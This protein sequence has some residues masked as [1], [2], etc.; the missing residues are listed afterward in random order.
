M[1]I[2]SCL[3]IFILGSIGC[4]LGSSL[5]ALI[6]ARAVQGLGGGGLIAL[7]LTIIGDVVAPRERA[8]YQGYFSG[9]WA[10]S[11]VAG[12]GLGGLLAEHLHWSMIFWL[13][14]PL[15]ALA[16]VV[17]DRP[18]R[19]LQAERQQHRLDWSGAILIMATTVIFLLILSWGG[20]RF[21][22]LSG[23][24]IGL[25]I[26]L[27][28]LGTWLGFHLQHASEPLLPMDVLRNPIVLAASKPDGCRLLSLQ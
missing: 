26:V 18:L 12:P 15:A 9:V 4:A 23:P 16:I 5:F 8:K 19:L 1:V 14:L 2:L 20:A 24:I 21:A 17:M 10:L 28:A 27:L 25:F 7:A 6:A 11:S 3:G 13:N 22:W